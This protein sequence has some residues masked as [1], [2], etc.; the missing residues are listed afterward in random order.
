MGTKALVEVE[1]PDGWELADSRMRQA[2]PGESFLVANGDVRTVHPSN[3]TEC[4]RL[5]VM[6]RQ[7]WNWPAWLKAPW[8]AR[9]PSGKWCGYEFEP[10]LANGPGG[11]NTMWQCYGKHGPIWDAFID[12]TPP[13]CTDWRESKRKNPNL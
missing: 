7:A 5:R 11:P 12:F 8:I 2:Q 1:I 6:V 13:P 3:A 4:R 10:R 9:T